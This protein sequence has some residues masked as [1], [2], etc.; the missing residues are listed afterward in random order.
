MVD[1]ANRLLES[2]HLASLRR[3]VETDLNPPTV[4]ASNG[5]TKETLH[6]YF[7]EGSHIPKK[8]GQGRVRAV[9]DEWDR[10]IAPLSASQK[11]ARSGGAG[12]GAGGD[13][14]KVVPGFGK[15]RVPFEAT[16]CNKNLCTVSGSSEEDEGDANGRSRGGIITT[17]ARDGTK[18]I[19]TGRAD[20]KERGPELKLGTNCGINSKIHSRRALSLAQ[21]SISS[22]TIA[23]PAEHVPCVMG[24]KGYGKKRGRINHFA[25]KT[26]PTTIASLDK[27]NGAENSDP[28][29]SNP[30]AL[31]LTAVST[32]RALT[33]R[34]GW[35]LPH[36][37]D[38]TSAVT[39]PDRKNRVLGKGGGRRGTTCS[40][41]DQF[42]LNSSTNVPTM[43]SCVSSSGTINSPSRMS[44]IMLGVSSGITDDH[45]P[46]NPPPNTHHPSFDNALP[47]V[48]GTRG[49]LGSYTVNPRV[50]ADL[51]TENSS[52]SSYSNASQVVASAIAGN[53]TAHVS[54]SATS[55]GGVLEDPAIKAVGRRG[56]TM[57]EISSEAIRL[58]PS[59]SDTTGSSL[60]KQ[61]EIAA[62]A[63]TT[64]RGGGGGRV[65]PWQGRRGRGSRRSSVG[66]RCVGGERTVVQRSRCV[67][68]GRFLGAVHRTHPTVLL[69]SIHPL[70][71]YSIDFL[72]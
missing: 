55:S 16:S 29:A 11:V 25:V 66:G 67:E 40:T 9:E 17:R 7:P 12:T 37:L 71:T 42:F 30:D 43:G 63:A 18:E 27:P 60:S 20:Q 34:L 21:V 58:Y 1:R 15:V 52:P 51:G 56:S 10:I 35:N 31:D 57:G 45:N 70:Y 8:V 32:P 26:P 14:T 38:P 4:P 3:A 39:N 23:F 19:L 53:A 62:G 68:T 54:P 2:S 44:A 65:G 13:K 47:T 48:N 69:Y 61:S 28:S 5:I 41:R 59:W 36:E 49:A 24:T 22:K 72:V 33:M 6:L 46:L 50:V 64:S